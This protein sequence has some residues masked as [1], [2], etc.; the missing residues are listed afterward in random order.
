MPGEIAD[1]DT[2]KRARLCFAIQLLHGK[3]RLYEVIAEGKKVTLHAVADTRYYEG[4]YPYVTGVLPGTDRTEEV[5]VL[6]HTSEQGAQD[7]ATGVAANIEA[8]A[9]LNKLIESGKLSRPQRTIRVLLMPELYG[10][11]TYITKHQDRMRNTVAAMTV[12]TP[13]ASYDLA[14]TEYTLYSN[15]HVAKSW[16]DALILRVTHASL[17]GRTVPGTYPN[18]QREP[19]PT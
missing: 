19:M 18:T 3:R 8:L 7:N 12:D 15:P 9:T 16:T 2:R 17:A 13:A 10:S 14:G 11:L 1:G 4:R 5:L 6:G